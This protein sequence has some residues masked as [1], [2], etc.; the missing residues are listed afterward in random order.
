LEKVVDATLTKP[1]VIG[2][3]F[4]EQFNDFLS[5][6]A[7]EAGIACCCVNRAKRCNGE[8]RLQQLLL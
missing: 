4:S 5:Q 8:N 2:L 7:A 6:L 1:G 3:S